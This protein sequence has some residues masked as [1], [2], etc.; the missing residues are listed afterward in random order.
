M[1]ARCAAPPWSSATASTSRRPRASLCRHARIVFSH[2]LPNCLPPLIVVATVQIANA[3]ALEATLSFLGIGVPITEPSLGLLIANG[4][5]VSAVR[6]VLDQLLP[7]R[8]AADHDR[9][10][11]TSSAISCATCSTRVCGADGAAGGRSAPTLEVEDLETWFETSEGVVKAVDGVS[12]ER[13]PR[14]DPGAGRRIRL[15]Q[16]RHR[17]LDPGPGRPAG[18]DRRR[19]DPLR[20]RGPGRAAARSACATSAAAGSR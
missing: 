8:G 5:E 17:L 10:A 4:Y 20:R 19:R 3:I 13:R 9:R 16:D 11:S 7:G 2:L 12:F 18:P 14:R 1:P 6:P 15:R